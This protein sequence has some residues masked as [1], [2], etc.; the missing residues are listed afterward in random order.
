MRNKKARKAPEERTAEAS[1]SR[2]VAEEAESQ[3]WYW[4][5]VLRHS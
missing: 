4:W 3:A 5:Y 2:G 1:K